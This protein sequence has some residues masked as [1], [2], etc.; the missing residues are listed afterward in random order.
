MHCCNLVSNNVFAGVGLAKMDSVVSYHA[1]VIWLYS[2][3]TVATHNATLLAL[4]HHYRKDWLL[5]YIRQSL[6]FVNLLLSCVFSIPLFQALTKGFDSLPVPIACVWK[7]DGE[8][9]SYP[10]DSAPTPYIIIAAL[11]TNSFTFGLAAWYLHKEHE[12]FYMQAQ[13]VGLTLMAVVVG[14]AGT[15]VTGI[16]LVFRRPIVA[17]GDFQET[18]WNYGQLLSVIYILLP[19]FTAVEMCRDSTT[20]KTPAEDNLQNTEVQPSS[21][22]ETLYPRTPFI[23]PPASDYFQRHP[24]GLIGERRAQ[25]V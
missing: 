10:S 4:A 20:A 24:G 9:V 21:Y 16:S 8:D 23:L 15:E 17:L 13:A 12:R 19:T 14:W 1:L 7:L 5:R 18:T 2:I 22:M 11:L 3:L 25:D 6:M